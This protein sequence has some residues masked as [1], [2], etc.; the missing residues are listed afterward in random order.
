ME[1]ATR[2][3]VRPEHMNHHQT[4]YAGYISEWVTEAA[5][6]GV[7]GLLKSTENV[8]LAAVKEIS[9]T[10]EVVSGVILELWQ[11]TKRIGT[12]SVEIQVTGRNFLTGEVI[13]PEAPSLSQWTSRAEKSRMDCDKVLFGSR[14][15]RIQII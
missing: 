9:V 4:L 7:T 15:R 10:K 6:I 2:H 5:M 14:R 13:L 11:E 12:T 3:F 1:I 8:V